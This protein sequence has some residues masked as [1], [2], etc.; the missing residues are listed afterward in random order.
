MEQKTTGV[1]TA[2]LWFICCFPIGYGGFGQSGKGW[3]WVLISIVTGG[4]GSLVM[5][6]DYWMSFNAQQHR[7]LEPFEFFPK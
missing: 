3:T 6:V 1:S 2:I 7:E 5:I 4:I